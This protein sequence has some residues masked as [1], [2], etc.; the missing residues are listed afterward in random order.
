MGCSKSTS[1][2]EVHYNST[3]PH[4][5][6]KIS[7]KQSNLTTKATTER[8]IKPKLSGRKEIIKIRG[9]INETKMKKMRTRIN[10]SK[11]WFFNK[12][13]LWMYA[14]Q[15]NTTSLAGFSC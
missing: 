8:T 9:E 13:K 6:R 15:Y 1:E 5:T 11:S 3:S 12:I 7:S 2:R 4:E 10:K 14:M